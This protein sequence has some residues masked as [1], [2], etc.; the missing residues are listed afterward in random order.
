VYSLVRMLTL[1]ALS[2]VNAARS[3]YFTHGKQFLG[4][5]CGLAKTLVTDLRLDKP[6]QP[7]GCPSLGPG[8]D[9]KEV[10]KSEGSRVFLAV[11]TLCA[12]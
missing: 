7:T 10:R 12:K 5:M 1:H 4:S 6:A 9:D 11:F 2:T 8:V 3:P